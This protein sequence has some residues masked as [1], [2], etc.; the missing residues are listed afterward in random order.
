MTALWVTGAHGFLGR[1]VVAAA[2]GGHKPIG[3]IGHGAAA[4]PAGVHAVTASIDAPGLDALAAKTGA[5]DAVIHLAGGAS[6]GASLADPVADESRTVGSTRALL[7]WLD[8]NAPRA[9]LVAASSAAV[10]GAATAERLAEDAPTAPVSPYGANKLAM[11]REI[12]ESGQPSVIVRLFSLHGPSLRKQILWD[13]HRRMAAGETPLTLG[14]TGAEARDFMAGEDAAE[15]LLALAPHARPGGVV[16]NGGTGVATS[17]AAL[18]ALATRGRGVEIRFSGVSRPGDPAR[19]VADT[20]RLA[21]TGF[22][23]RIDLA[24]GIA[25]TMAGYQAGEAP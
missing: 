25:A 18:A 11:E 16:L 8:R 22:R 6:V 24:E 4:H 12:R 13:L 1:L 20:S 3:A 7:A 15:L 19:L 21:A 10:Y 17:I 2:A 5:P 9:R 14:G 23:P